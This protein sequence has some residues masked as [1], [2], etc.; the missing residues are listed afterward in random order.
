MEV[1]SFAHRKTALLLQPAYCDYQIGAFE[2]FHQPVEDILIVL[3]PGPKIFF[4]YELR[5]ANCLNGQLVITH[6]PSYPSKNG[7]QKKQ[8]NKSNHVRKHN[9]Q[10][11]KSNLDNIPVFLN[12]SINFCFI[13]RKILPSTPKRCERRVAAMI[14]DALDRADAIE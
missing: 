7:A 12:Y 1:S 6:F 8:N 9:Q 4:Q 14:S 11:I 10:E 2:N 5:F 3:R 13:S